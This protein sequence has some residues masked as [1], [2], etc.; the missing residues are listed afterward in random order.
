MRGMKIEARFPKRVFGGF[1]LAVAAVA[2]GWF[3]NAAHAKEQHRVTI[4]YVV[5]PAQ[6]L[7]EGLDAVAVIDAGVRTEGTREDAREKKWAKIA[8]DMIESMLIR[9]GQRYGPPLRVAN[10]RQ[11]KQVLEEQDLMLSGLVDGVTAARAG[12]LLAVQ[13]LVTTQITIHVDQSKSMKSAVDWGGLI[14]DVTSR[15]LSDRKDRREP[16]RPP[17]PRVR[18]RRDPRYRRYPQIY[19]RRVVP[20]GAPPPPVDRR[21]VLH[22]REVEEISRM[23]TVQCTFNLIDAVTGETILQYAPPTFQKH[24]KQSPDFFFGALVQEGDLDPVDHFIGELV[25]RA[26]RQFAGMI[27]PVEVA[28]TYEL[29][30]RDEGEAGVR[31]LRADDYETALLRLQKAHREDP[32]EPDT[33]FAL[34][35]VCELMGDPQRALGYYRQVVAMDVDDDELA[36]YVAAKKRVT[37]HAKRILPSA[38]AKVRRAGSASAPVTDPPPTTAPAAGRDRVRWFTE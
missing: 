3:A 27:V 11:M 22:T 35:A 20:G 33:V 29:I 25:E 10:R 15:A 7:P 17:Q 4:S 36:V 32:D 5:A 14:G 28:E 24:D 13:G 1:W 16:R 31:A 19:H 8:A 30:G 37:A 38:T 21:P 6:P 12:K 26:S 23:L 34:G 9:G 18:S 2:A